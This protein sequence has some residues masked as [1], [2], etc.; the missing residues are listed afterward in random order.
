MNTRRSK[1][2]VPAWNNSVLASWRVKPGLL[3][4]SYQVKKTGF[5]KRPTMT[6]PKAKNVNL[7]I[8]IV[9]YHL[10]NVLSGGMSLATGMGSIG[11]VTSNNDESTSNRS[12]RNS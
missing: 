2:S 6:R 10:G 3:S 5:T 8:A 11:K 1:A 12:R 7:R 4:N 9:Q